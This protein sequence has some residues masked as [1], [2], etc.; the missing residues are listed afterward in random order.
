MMNATLIAACLVASPFQM[1]GMGGPAGITKPLEP[2]RLPIAAYKLENGLR[3][4]LHRDASVPNVTVCVAY[5]VGSKN[6]TPGKTGF[7]HFFEHMMFRG[8]QHVPNYDIPLREA[9]AESNAFT[10]E[11]MT[12]YFETVAPNYLERAL[13]LEADRLA[14]L[15]SALNQEKFDIEREVVK[16]ERLQSVENMPYGLSDETILA[17]LYPK[18][19]P[20]SWPVIGSMKDLNAATLDD[21]K[22]FFSE[23][24]NPGNAVL[25][26]VGNFE[27]ADAERLIGLY[28]GGIPRGPKV[29]KVPSPHVPPPEIAVTLRDSVQLPRL[30]WVWPTV[31][32]ASAEAPALDMLAMILADGDASRLERALVRDAKLAKDVNVSSDTKDLAGTFQIVATAA[33]GKTLVDVAR[34]LEAEIGRVVMEKAGEDELA[35]AR[36]KYESDQYKSLIN[37]LGRAIQFTTGWAMHNDPEWYRTDIARHLKVTTSQVKAAARTYLTPKKLALRIIPE[38]SV[39]EQI[40]PDWAKLPGSTSEPTFSAPRFTRSRLPNGVDLVVAPWTTLP[41][42]NVSILLPAGT[43]DDPSGKSGLASLTASLLNQGTKDLTSTQLVEALD[44]LGFSASVSAGQDWTV[45]SYSG[46][47]R[48]WMQASI[49]IGAMLE[50]PR[51]DKADFERERGLQLARLAQGPDDVNWIAS[52]AFPVVLNGPGHPYAN[53]GAGSIASV[54]GLTLKEVKAFYHDKLLA[55]RPTIIVAGAVEA[56]NV[57]NVLA[58]ALGEWH[59]RGEATASRPKAEPKRSASTL[60]LVDKPGASQSVIVVGRTWTARSDPRYAAAEVGNHVL[61]GTFLSRLNNNLREVHGYTYGANSRFG[62]RRGSGVWLARTAVRRDVTAESIREILGEFDGLRGKHGLTSTEVDTARDAELRS[63]PEAFA[64]PNGIAGAVAEI[65][66]FGLPDDTIARFP[67]DLKSVKV[68]EVRKVMEEAVDPNARVMLV[69]GDR[70]EIEPKL[71]RLGFRA[72]E[73][74]TVD[75]MPSGVA[76]DPK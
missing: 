21:L 30:Y 19:H 54:K 27:V 45:V 38:K 18:A 67:S 35:R 40:G 65:V 61:G 41:V 25:C 75:G 39:D 63:Y 55:S 73:V 16:N 66:E 6:E 17:N 15:P 9:G 48:H 14:H 74:L 68:D 26:L 49:L 33:E 5:H 29:V 20:Y 53:P 52:R 47:A 3:V 7:A 1:G 56:Q 76:A 60:Y 59:P 2:P 12:V 44:T 32:D 28:F 43:A 46:L 70:K 23:F 69:V 64:T 51:F 57:S 36:V 34:V 31:A 58:N 24:Y 8:T 22:R 42:V 13:Y 10:T 72:I 4:V 50:S 71:K 62:Y 11:D 37:P